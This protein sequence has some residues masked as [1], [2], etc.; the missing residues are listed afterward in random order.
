[1]P[2][3]WS[4]TTLIFEEH[5]DTNSWVQHVLEE[6]PTYFLGVPSMF[7]LI[8]ESLSAETLEVLVPPR[9]LI[10]GGATMPPPLAARLI[11][12]FPGSGLRNIYALT[13]SGPTGTMMAPE[14][15]PHRLDTVGRPMTG[16]SVR[17]L[18][19]EGHDVPV[20][21][22]GEITF[23]TEAR[24]TRYLGNEAA[25]RAALDDDGWLRSGDIGKLDEDGFVY[26]LDRKNDVI[27]RG[28]FNVYP[29]EVEAAL[30]DHPA[31]REAAVIGVPHTILGE[32][33]RGFIVLAKGKDVTIEDLKVFCRERIAGYKVPRQIEVV[34][35]L[36]R[37]AMGKILR[38]NLRDRVAQS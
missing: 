3:F 2:A 27:L 9:E 11:K 19:P 12:T 37:N 17:I 4:G 24:M 25:T 28:G 7:A 1:M 16:V 29:A 21:Q 6:Q 15:A 32:D 38:I 22:T 14:D 33:V 26:L 23:L 20:G 8:I 36:P 34:D 31:V 5:F 13:E 35:E 10:Y 18:D 30:V